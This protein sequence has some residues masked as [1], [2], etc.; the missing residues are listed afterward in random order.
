MGQEEENQLQQRV[1]PG[2]KALLQSFS[3]P[4]IL[5]TPCT[6]VRTYNAYTVALCRA[7]QCA[8]KYSRDTYI[9][10]WASFS[11]P[12]ISVMYPYGL[13]GQVHIA[14]PTQSHLSLPYSPAPHSPAGLLPA[15][16][17]SLFI[18]LTSRRAVTDTSCTLSLN[19]SL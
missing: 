9:V 4:L 10:N 14:P 1:E 19:S 3:Q 7:L 5:A 8:G 11:N 18:L 2:T 16:I 6:Y 17:Q 12:T 15:E 13:P